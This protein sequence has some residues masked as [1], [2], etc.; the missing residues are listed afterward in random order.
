MCLTHGV[1]LQPTT[2]VPVVISRVSQGKEIHG[3]WPNPNFRAPAEVDK[4]WLS[5]AWIRR[6]REEA[7]SQVSVYGTGGDESRRE[8][9][10]L[11]VAKE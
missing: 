9:C 6:G 5:G 10:K 7:A 8:R 4:F 1:K 2:I 3:E 11:V